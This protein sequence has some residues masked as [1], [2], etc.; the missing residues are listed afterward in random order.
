M[1]GQLLNNQLESIC[2]ERLMVQTDI[3]YSNLP[4]EPDE[5]HKIPEIMKLLIYYDLMSSS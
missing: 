4:G 2:K 1:I 3:L 5:I